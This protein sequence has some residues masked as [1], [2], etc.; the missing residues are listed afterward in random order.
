MRIT[1]VY[2]RI[3]RIHLMCSLIR[4]RERVIT[5]ISSL[6]KQPKALK[7]RIRWVHNRVKE[8]S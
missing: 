6:I 2:R 3:P 1:I 4:L 5:A 8:A 7:D